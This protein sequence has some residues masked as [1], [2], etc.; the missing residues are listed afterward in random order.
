MAKSA[1]V[2]KL[3][4]IMGGPSISDPPELDWLTC[5]YCGAGSNDLV[6]ISWRA[7]IEDRDKEIL[8]SLDGPFSHII[9]GVYCEVCNNVVWEADVDLSKLKLKCKQKE[10]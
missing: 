6:Y 4:D 2:A 10:V 7:A 1:L 8:S 5:P 3:W 9:E